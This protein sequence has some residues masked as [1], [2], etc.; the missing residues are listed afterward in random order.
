M[1]PSLKHVQKELQI[2]E[3]K[4]VKLYLG[5]NCYFFLLLRMS[6]FTF[7][8]WKSHSTSG[9]FVCLFSTC[10]IESA[11]S[12]PAIACNNLR[13]EEGTLKRIYW[14]SSFEI[15]LTPFCKNWDPRSFFNFLIKLS[16]F[17]LRLPNPTPVSTS[18][19]CSFCHSIIHA[20]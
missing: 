4:S 18:F 9:I 19:S 12:P 6:V 11:L 7:Q 13:Q 17:Y 1:N 15:H 3:R 8:F 20:I 5:V 14:L 2:A 10:I 16:N